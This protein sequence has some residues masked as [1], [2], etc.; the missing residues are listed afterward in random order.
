MKIR[1]VSDK[2]ASTHIQYVEETKCKLLE[3][4]LPADGKACWVEMNGKQYYLD[5]TTDEGIAECNPADNDAPPPGDDET[6]QVYKSVH[7]DLHRAFNDQRFTGYDQ[8]TGE[9]NHP[10]KGVTCRVLKRYGSQDDIG[11]DCVVGVT[12]D[13]YLDEGRGK[14]KIAENVGWDFE[15]PAGLV[16]VAANMTEELEDVK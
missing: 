16:A 13:D 1:I 14:S 3:V 12:E 15:I 6:M 8:T 2:Q 7:A 5:D 11:N 9:N 10:L 4:V